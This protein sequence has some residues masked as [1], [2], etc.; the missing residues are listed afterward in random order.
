MKKVRLENYNYSTNGYYFITLST[1]ISNQY[2]NDYKKHSEILKQFI[3][4]NLNQIPYNYN[5]VK[6][7]EFK[8]MH[9]H[10]HCIIIIDSENKMNKVSISTIVGE[11]K[12][13]VFKDWYTYIKKNDLSIMAKFWQK[14]FY[15]RVIR[16]EKELF[17][18]R[19]YIRFNH[20]KHEF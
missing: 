18:V 20:L 5:G 16:N 14:G 2:L 8:I 1:N 9:D 4:N 11:F 3:N 6:L 12:S 10:I 7:D 19:H 13:C 15:E 17:N